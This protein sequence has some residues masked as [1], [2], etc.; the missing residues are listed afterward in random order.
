MLGAPS[1]TWD[2]QPLRIPR[3]QVRLILYYL[4][5]QSSPVNRNTLTQLLW[6]EHDEAAARKLLREALS[7]LKAALPDPAVLK[8]TSKNMQLDP[9]KTYSD[10]LELERLTKPIMSGAVIESDARLPEIVYQKISEALALCRGSMTVSDI[11]PVVSSGM[12]NYFHFVSQTYDHIRISLQERLTNHC[13]AKG[14]LNEALYWLSR[15]HEID[16]FSNDNNYLMV[17]CLKDSGREKDA[18][19][20]IA[21]LKNLYDGT[22]GQDFP[23][24]IISLKTTLQ[25][26]NGTREK[27]L[28]EWPGMELGA[29]PFV[30]REDLLAKL[31]NAYHRKGM[32][33][34][35]G[36]SGIGKN[37]LVQE[38]YLNLQRKPRL[39]FC[40]GRP[41]IGCAPFEPLIEGL[42]MAV[43]P[44][45][46]QALP[47]EFKDSLRDF[48]PELQTVY[49]VVQAEP[50]SLGAQEDFLRICAALHHLFVQLAQKKPLLLVID[51]FIWVDDATIDFLSYLS[52]RGFF[53]THGLLI[54]ISRKEESSLPFEVFIDR[55]QM[56]GVLETI[57]VPPLTRFES[58]LLIQRIL[59]VQPS[60]P[61]LEKF[62]LQTGGNPYFITEGLKS[63]H[64]IDFHFQDFSSAS[65]FPV[66]DSI[67][68]LIKEKTRLLPENTQKVLWAGS[69]LGQF[70]RPE[71]VE[72][73]EDIPT[74][75]MVSALEELE[76]LSILSIRQDANG[77]TGYFFDHNQIREEVLRG[78]SP[79]RKRH[80]HLQAVHALESVHGEKPELEAEYA[81]HYEEAGEVSRAFG[82]WL[83]A[84]DFARTRFSKSD[85]YFAYERAN[86]LV[87]RLP[88]NQLV[89]KI[90]ELVYTWGTYAYDLSDIDTC[91]KVYNMCLEYGEQTQNPLLLC[92]A[93]NGIA[94]VRDM[95]LEV[96]EGL[97]AAKRAQFYCDRSDSVALKLETSARLIILLSEKNEVQQAIKIGEEALQLLPVITN[98]R[99]MDAMVV[100]MTQ[101]GFMY[102][103]AGW[104]KKV[105]ELADKGL[106]LSLL[107]KRRSAKVQVA[108]VLAAGQ[109]YC[110][111]YQKSLQNALAVRDLAERLNYRWWLS[112]LDVLLG[113]LFLVKGDMDKSWTHSQLVLEREEPF[114]YGGIYA[115][116]LSLRGDIYRLLGETHRALQFFKKGMETKPESYMTL[117]CA[118]MYGLILGRLDPNQ[119]MKVLEKTI[120]TGDRT[121]LGLI[122]LQAK[123]GK[124]MIRGYIGEI[125]NLESEVAGISAE[126]K[127]RGFGT[128]SSTQELVAALV[129]KNKGNINKA[130]THFQELARVGQEMENIWLELY[131]FTGLMSIAKTTEEKKTLKSSVNSLLATIGTNTSQK[132]LLRLLYIFRKK[133]LDTH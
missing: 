5:T 13:I 102:L 57:N 82:A 126:M 46:W 41:L 110:G 37:R 48:F 19:D 114:E 97:E 45:E 107:V 100:I 27:E 2:G 99:E 86:A 33:S 113:R 130:K 104:P 60:E 90:D 78:M 66:P 89:E 109:Y 70:F 29:T 112:F 116:A 50:M 65:L 24:T 22:P 103:V 35:R 55:N 6:P 73:M 59:G 15:L 21:Y 85:R 74:D 54:L 98:N 106:N 124:C 36:A 111:E 132:P 91:I 75:E 133:M 101:L 26:Q 95:K 118:F 4:A 123:M 40:T 10:I 49:P 71:V 1:I 43:K 14:D 72:V 20:Y 42:R 62:Y 28:P 52:D 128:N 115:L 77:N 34:V 129:E 108:A 121:G 17:S 30:G 63:L 8:A 68:A 7:K 44:E 105:T 69:V 76:K 61:F 23:E 47:G 93:W 12:E 51:I 39:I 96:D 3:Q 53:R 64:S 94:R 58:D 81:Y 120:D 119:G 84:A 83:K 56:I 16:P 31:T 38:F 92:N 79:L 9:E 11:N 67:K 80:L 32:V 127:K 122:S 88:Q 18:I 125:D 25:Q 117:E 131:G 87:S